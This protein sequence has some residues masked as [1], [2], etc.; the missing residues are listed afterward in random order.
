MT[1]YL[2]Y[3]KYMYVGKLLWLRKNGGHFQY[4]LRK[5]MSLFS[6]KVN[7]LFITWF[8]YA[9]KQFQILLD[10]QN[11]TN[12]SPNIQIIIWGSFL[13]THFVFQFFIQ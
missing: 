7:F 5:N 8:H 11:E 3:E 10:V 12:P 1:A 9:T 13:V 2:N 4:S 6:Y